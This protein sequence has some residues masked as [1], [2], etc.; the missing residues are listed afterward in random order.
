MRDRGTRPAL[1]R[2]DRAVLGD[3]AVRR[4]LRV[5]DPA[6]VRADAVGSRCHGR[7][8]PQLA[9]R[10]CARSW[11]PRRSID[12]RQELRTY[13]CDGL[14]HYKVVPGLVVLA[15]T[16]ADVAA[17]VAACTEAGVPFV[18]RGS[19]TGLSGGALPH[20]DGVLIVT[21]RMRTILEIDRDGQRAVVE[22]GVINL[23]V[24]RAVAPA[25][26]YYAPDPSSQQV[27]SIGGNVAE[28]SGGAHCLKY[29]FT[30]NHVLGVE[31][32]DAVRRGGPDRRQGARRA[33][34]RPA[35]HDRRLRGHARHRDQGHRTAD[36][37]PRSRCRRCW[38]A[39]P[40][41]TRPGRRS[42]RSSPPA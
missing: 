26:Y 3:G 25:G 17:V 31:F 34:L 14:A 2:R 41:P 28:N 15:E 37:A 33:R 21:S 13:E 18:A 40:A 36:P 12:D 27:C 42:R 1:G 9:V 16:T 5:P 20:A 38:P 22:P 24:T 30:T 7:S 35:R 32:V 4:L 8:R 39:S 23:H 29:G 6:R 10:D 11:A 19:G